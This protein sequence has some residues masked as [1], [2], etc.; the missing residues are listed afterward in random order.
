MTN[1]KAKIFNWFAQLE[2]HGISQAELARKAHITQQ[3][4]SKVEN[5]NNCNMQTF[6][7]VC[8]ALGL[9][10]NYEHKKASARV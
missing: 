9:K 10:L 8:T 2:A 4:F 1:N 6:I 7:R 5:G 3:Q